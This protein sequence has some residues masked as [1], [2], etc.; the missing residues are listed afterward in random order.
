MVLISYGEG[1]NHVNYSKN[2]NVDTVESSYVNLGL[3][4]ISVKSKM[5]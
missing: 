5:F 3:L 2:F 4:Q 1:G